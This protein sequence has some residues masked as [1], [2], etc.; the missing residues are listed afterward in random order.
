VTTASSKPIS[1]HTILVV[2]GA[3][4]IGTHMVQGLLGA[5]HQVIVLDNLCRGHRELIPGGIFVAGDLGDAT[6]LDDIFSRHPVAAVMHFAAFSLVGES[7]EKPLAYYRNNV[8]R[9]VELLDA[10]VRH[11]V[12]NFIF[13]STA[14][15]YGEPLSVPIAEDHSCLPTNPYG[16]TKLTVE[17]L[18]ADCA[19]RDD[20]KYISLRYFN[21]AGA[22]P[23][24][25]LGERHEPETHLIP[26]VLQ[27][28]TGE[29]ERI[30]IYGTDYPTPDGTCIRDYIHVSDLVQ[31]HTLAMTS[32]LHGGA[33]AVYNLGNS[34]GYSVREVIDT[35][36]NVTGHSIPATASARRAGDP[37]VLIADSDKI[38]RQLGWKPRYEDLKT[39][40]ETA[41]T[42]HRR[43]ARR[44]SNK[45]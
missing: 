14:A 36:R 29:R 43:E 38:R 44:K 45:A 41:W 15:V 24:G 37:A 18:L 16:Q 32:L 4:Y 21:A 13:S 39:I 12:K 42:W 30:R 2:G 3:G 11:G 5:G 28:A 31:A 40:I 34:K 22:D 25:N 17:H 6:L 23:S 27:V 1:G 33:S 8:S 20:L 10:M 35:A 19:R 9:T 7:V 26:L